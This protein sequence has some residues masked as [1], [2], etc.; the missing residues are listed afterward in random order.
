VLAE[1][2]RPIADR[3]IAVKAEVDG[4]RWVHH[5]RFWIS[6]SRSWE[7]SSAWRMAAWLRSDSVACLVQRTCWVSNFQTALLLQGGTSET[8][9]K[10]VHLASRGIPTISESEPTPMESKF[11]AGMLQSSPAKFVIVLCHQACKSVRL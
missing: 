7:K 10:D 4:T 11:S 8:F 9:P 1:T 2:H 3:P 6:S 5:R